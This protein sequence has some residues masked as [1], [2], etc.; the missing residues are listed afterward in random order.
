MKH[1]LPI[2]LL[3]G[4]C[5]TAGEEDGVTFAPSR[6]PADDAKAM[7]CE[8]GYGGC[9][10]GIKPLWFSEQPKH[11]E[12]QKGGTKKI[13]NQRY[14]CNGGKRLYCQKNDIDKCKC[15]ED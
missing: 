10:E 14:E 12:I 4:L 1:L 2:L 8:P 13:K 7:N 15:I 3:I 9:I 5:G 11:I 6:T